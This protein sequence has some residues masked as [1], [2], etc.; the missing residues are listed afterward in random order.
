MHIFYRPEVSSKLVTK[1][2]LTAV[3]ILRLYIRKCNYSF[4]EKSVSITKWPM[5]ASGCGRVV[6]CGPS[7]PPAGCYHP[8]TAGMILRRGALQVQRQMPEIT[9]DVPDHRAW[10]CLLP[11]IF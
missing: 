2:Q 9:A 1:H 6:S 3:G 8:G 4:Y 5:P 10:Q 7:D 11:E